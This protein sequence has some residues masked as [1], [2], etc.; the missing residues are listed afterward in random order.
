MA[1]YIALCNF[2]DQGIRSVKDTTKRAEAVKQAAK[3][4][5][6]DMRETYWTVGQYDLVVVVDAPDDESA[7]A[8]SLSVGA[9]G[10]V[11]TQTLRAFS[12]DE[13]NRILTKVP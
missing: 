13:L 12:A 6:V 7:T 11:R 8:F 2:T 9:A 1:T 5:G 10:N 3:K 4:Q